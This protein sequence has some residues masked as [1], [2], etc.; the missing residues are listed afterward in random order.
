[1]IIKFFFLNLWH[2]YYNISSDSIFKTC[3]FKVIF[4]AKNANCVN[5]LGDIAIWFRIADLN[6]IFIINI[7]M[8]NQIDNNND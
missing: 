6:A 7:I 3:V 4:D 2:F 8:K 5:R 1:M